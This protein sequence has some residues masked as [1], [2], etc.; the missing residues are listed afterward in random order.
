MGLK[1]RKWERDALKLLDGERPTTVFTADGK[2]ARRVGEVA[3]RLRIRR[4]IYIGK[5]TRRGTTLVVDP[6]GK[7]RALLKELK[8]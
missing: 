3:S 7:L 5:D 4:S 2:T 6:H 1:L 8:S